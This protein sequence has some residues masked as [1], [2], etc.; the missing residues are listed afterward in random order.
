MKSLNEVCERVE[1]RRVRLDEVTLHRAA[2]DQQM[3]DAVEQR[4][5]GLSV[6]ARNVQRRRLRGF[7]RARIDHD[8]FGLAPVRITRCHMIG[9][10]MQGFAPMKI[11]ASLSSKSA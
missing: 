2:R 11:S 10:A 6:A 9:C 1:A 5:I 4:E 8:D 3:R 7:G